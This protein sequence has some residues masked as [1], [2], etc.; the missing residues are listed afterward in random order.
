MLCRKDTKKT[1]RLIVIVHAHG[2][3]T[4]RKAIVIA[5]MA[6]HGGTGTNVVVRPNAE[7]VHLEGDTTTTTIDIGDLPDTR[8]E[9]MGVGLVAA[10]YIGRLGEC[11]IMR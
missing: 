4:S 6:G 10:E 1:Q 11:P 9:T 7:K 5:R 8:T 2:G 3:L